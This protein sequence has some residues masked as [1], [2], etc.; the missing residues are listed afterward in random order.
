MLDR[1][2][3]RPNRELAD[4]AHHGSVSSIRGQIDPGHVI[5]A[6]ILMVIIV[7]LIPVV[8]EIQSALASTPMFSWLTAGLFALLLVAGLVAAGLEGER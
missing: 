2:N 8:L 3:E 1:Q 6:M 5:V 7:P 4:S